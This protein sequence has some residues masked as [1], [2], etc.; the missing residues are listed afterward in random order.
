MCTVAGGSD[1]KK[2]SHGLCKRHYNKAVRNG[3]I[4]KS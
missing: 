2:E 4:K 3:E 1:L